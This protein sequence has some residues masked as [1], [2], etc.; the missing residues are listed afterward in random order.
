MALC[1]SNTVLRT[2]RV[3]WKYVGRIEK[4]TRAEHGIGHVNSEK[5]SGRSCLLIVVRGGAPSR[6]F[7]SAQYMQQTGRQ[8][9]PWAVKS[10]HVVLLGGLHAS[11]LRYNGF[12][13]FGRSVRNRCVGSTRK[14][15]ERRNA[16]HSRASFMATSA[17]E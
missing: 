11:S 7:T 4:N 9:P 14:S 16:A 1:A 2:Q 12:P 13:V 17:A 8:V 15:L 10:S 3:Q 5:L 6:H